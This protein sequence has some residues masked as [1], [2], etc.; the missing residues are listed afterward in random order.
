MNTSLRPVLARLSLEADSRDA[1]MMLYGAFVRSEV[2]PVPTGCCDGCKCCDGWSG[3]LTHGEISLGGRLMN[4]NYAEW[5]YEDCAIWKHLTLL[6]PGDSWKK[7]RMRDIWHDSDSKD[8]LSMYV[9]ERFKH[10]RCGR[11]TVA[12]MVAAA[13]ELRFNP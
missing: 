13:I 5:T 12:G 2:F 10:S 4:A 3:P 11:H 1:D 7:R 6:W 8:A 9:A